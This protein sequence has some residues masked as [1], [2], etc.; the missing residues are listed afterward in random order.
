MTRLE[1]PSSINTYNLCK[2]KY[3][4]TYKLN[5]PRKDSISTLTG[6]AVHDALENFFKIDI[7]N[8][9][10]S[11]YEVALR[12]NLMHLFNSAWTTAL[13]ALLRLE[14]DKET[15]RHYYNDSM[16]MLQNF[17]EDFLATLN[18]VI[19]GVT[20]QEAFNKIKPETEVYF[21][22]EKHNVHGYLD[23]ILN[24][25]GDIYI[26]DYKTSS[27]DN[28]TEDYKLQLAIYALMFHE[29]HG[30][31]PHKL[32]LHFL[33]HGTKKYVNV[34]EELIEKAKRECELIKLNTQTDNIED[35]DKNPGPWCKWRD[36]QCSFYD[37]CFGVK[38]LNDYDNLIQIE[39][40]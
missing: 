8:I 22:S 17:I 13:P 7:N 5:L 3:Y 40:K 38:K 27:R 31:L 19:N 6:K 20:F 25:N 33:R 23:A 24:F 14:N 21:Y 11:N 1:S 37:N 2:R 30:K 18:S 35:Y 32:G 34:N 16:Y 29:K 12:Q 15:I 28:V 26:L 36:G 9:D 4:Y 10:K 39:K